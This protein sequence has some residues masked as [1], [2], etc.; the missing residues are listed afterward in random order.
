M[1]GVRNFRKALLGEVHFRHSN[2]W[3]F[4][5]ALLTKHGQSEK[6]SKL[7][8]QTIARSFMHAQ[9][10][11]DDQ[12]KDYSM[13]ILIV[14]DQEIICVAFSEYLRC[15]SSEIYNGPLVVDTAFSLESAFDTLNRKQDIDYVF[16]DL[17]LNNEI[18]GENTIRKFREGTH[19]Q[20]KIVVLAGLPI[21]SEITIRT[22]RCCIADFGAH[23]ILMKRTNIQTMFKAIRCILAGERWVPD[24]IWTAFANNGTVNNS[25]FYYRLNLTP[26]EWNVATLLTKG[27]PDKQIAANLN[28]Q[29]SYVRQV[30]SHIYRKLDV[31]NRTGAA[32]KVRE[33]LERV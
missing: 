3:P 7:L 17:D 30:T 9:I 18:Y 33:Y 20:H 26:C 8:K 31:S 15:N 6:F 21:S 14:D 27:L 5:L 32:M 12:V 13:R 24:V 11:K 2:G 10:V 4:K 1:A 29:P 23:S 28:L 25:K 22:F 16:I 19:Q